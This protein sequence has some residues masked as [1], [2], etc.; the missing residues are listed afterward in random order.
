MR[1]TPPTVQDGKYGFEPDGIDNFA[2]DSTPSETLDAETAEA[3]ARSAYETSTDWLQSGRR[4]RWADSIR[5]FNSLHPQ[6]SKY[7]SREYAGR[8]TLYRPQTRTMIRKDEAATA[9]AF[10][11][12]EDVLNIRAD[13][14]DDPQQ[15]ASA[16]V[17]KALIQYR[18]TKTIPWFQTIIG[19]RQDASVFG[20]AVAKVYWQYE[21]RILGNVQRPKLDSVYGFPILDD[22]GNPQT[23]EYEQFEVVKDRP[24]IDLVAP[25]NIR[26]DPGADWRDPI[27]TSPY[28]IELLP[29]YHQD[30]EAKIASGEWH[31]VGNSALL[32]SIDHDPTRIERDHGRRSPGSEATSPEAYSICWVRSNII[33]WG[34]K[35]YQ[36][37]TIGG[38]GELLSDPRPIEEVF[39]HGVRPYVVGTVVLEAHKNFPSSKIELTKDLQRVSNDAL[40]LR[41]DAVKMSLHPRQFYKAGSGI[42][43][44]DLRSMIPG[45]AIAIKGERGEPLTNTVA[46]DRPPEPGQSSFTEQQL[47]QLDW[48]GLTGAFSNASVQ[49]SQWSQQSAT[50]MH[51]MSGEA[52]GVSEY[53][54]RCFAETFVEPVLNMLIKLEQAYETDENILALA[55]NKAQL[56]QRFGLDK[57]TDELLN[58][59]VTTR[60]N[61]GI[62]A[63]NPSMRLRAFGQAAQTLQSLFASPTAAMGLNFHEIVSEIMSQAGY[64]DGERFIKP[65]FDP[66][67]VMMQMEQAKA[68]G[69]GD[70]GQSRV[71]AAKIQADSR[72]QEAQIHAQIEAAK[73]RQ[74]L[75]KLQIQQQSENWRTKYQE[76]QER[77]STMAQAHADAATQFVPALQA[78]AQ[79]HTEGSQNIN[80]SHAALVQSHGQLAKQAESHHAATAQGLHAVAQHLADLHSA[81]A[82]QHA[83]TQQHLHQIAQSQ[84]ALAN[85]QQELAKHISAPRR[86]IRDKSGK[87]QGVELVPQT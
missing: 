41:F 42:E 71:Q 68:G 55:G 57:V 79:A 44:N 24:W 49:A 18:L 28:V 2:D 1:D 22:E 39:L 21:E 20:I 27:N 47:N 69:K 46:W 48:D 67:Q 75:Q 60:C 7:L 82:E 70:N 77:D 12:N 38:A 53:E 36:F 15:Q 34:N 74:D 83:A 43:L 3:L 23:E 66:A 29:M 9:T 5:A 56:F 6:G 73:L 85:A 37:F 14:D 8:S 40:N 32:S 4:G 52:S 65:G 64:R 58:G 19:A 80:Q 81:H 10:F 51:L 13:D 35:D 87:V 45:K 72:L 59:S 84:A 86:V 50:G 78:I 11:S 61:V 26:F 31:D 63:T 62:G 30:I 33:R 54:L 17:L 76:D 25:E 16:E